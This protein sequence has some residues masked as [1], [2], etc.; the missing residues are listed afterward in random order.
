MCHSQELGG[1][2][3]GSLEHSFKG[4]QRSSAFTC[5]C[6]SQELGGGFWN[7]LSK[8]AKDLPRLHV[9]ATPKSWGGGG[10]GGCLKHSF[11][12]GQRSSAFT[13]MCHS[14]ELG[15]GGVFGT[16]FQRWPKIFRVYMY[17]PLPRVG[18]GE[19]GTLFQRWPK[20]FRVY[21]YVPLPRVGGGGGA[22]SLEHSFK[23]VRCF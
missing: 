6:H 20:N 7:T 8:V 19:F 11:K 14:Q 17:V 16:L 21:M 2:G 3:G 23:G 12:G 9:C 5:M 4:G 22:G 1:G 13:C 18:G 15:G 10:G